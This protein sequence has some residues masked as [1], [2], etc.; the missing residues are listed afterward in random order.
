M[1]HTIREKQKL[2]ARVRR[3]VTELAPTFQRYRAE[4][5]PDWSAWAS[6]PVEEIQR[7]LVGL[8]AALIHEIKAIRPGDL[9]RIGV[10]SSFGRMSLNLWVEFFLVHEAHHLYIVLQRLREQS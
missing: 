6:L 1:S 8:R 4:E 7:R 10:H 3:I 9:S 5:D 2:L